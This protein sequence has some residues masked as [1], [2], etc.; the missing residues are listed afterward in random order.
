MNLNVSDTCSDHR[1]G[2]IYPSII[3][4][5]D[6]KGKY[7]LH[8]QIPI[9]RDPSVIIEPP[10]GTIE[11]PAAVIVLIIVKRGFLDPLKAKENIHKKEVGP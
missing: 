9:C 2:N 7:N 3:E 10:H 8:Y 6:H 1:L 5:S 11:M 4:I